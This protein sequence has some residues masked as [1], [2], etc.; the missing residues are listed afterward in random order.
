MNVVTKT[1][2]LCQAILESEEFKELIR[3]E[4]ILENDLDARELVTEFNVLQTKLQNLYNEGKKAT[5]DDFKRL[6][7]LE[8]EMAEDASVGP[9]LK[10]QQIFTDLLGKINNMINESIRTRNTMGKNSSSGSNC[11]CGGH[12]KHVPLSY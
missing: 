10:A 8:Q 11:N 2:E 5:K 4:T 6:R 7:E 9:Y 12:H 3:S 1:E